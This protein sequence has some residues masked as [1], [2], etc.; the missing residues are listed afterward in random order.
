MAA[1]GLM[2]V[3][4]QNRCKSTSAVETSLALSLAVVLD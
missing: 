2:L 1:A 3:R 4:P